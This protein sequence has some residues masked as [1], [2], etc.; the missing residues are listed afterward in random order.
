VVKT[1]ERFRI[2]ELA[3]AVGL[4]AA[5]VWGAASLSRQQA[6][7]DKVVRLHILANSDS[8]ADQ[9]LK[10]QVRDA[11]TARTAALLAESRSRAEAETVLRRE[12]PALEALAA[13]EIAKRGY[14][15]PVCARLEEAEFPTRVYDDFT[16][17]AGRYLA[18][19]VLIGA[20]EGHNWWCVV[21]PP[22]C[23][24]S[25]SEFA[26]AASADGLSKDDV[27][28]LTESDEGYVLKFKSIE[29][30]EALRSQFS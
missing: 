10:L 14:H 5:L 15:Y 8:Q 18:L 25:T 12:L 13:Q 6:L 27:G 22:L 7:A 1:R 26:E 4:A 16:L 17:P 23:A 30:W 9:A 20:G 3:L 11:V 19:R 2:W 29:L 28:L 21:F 24:A